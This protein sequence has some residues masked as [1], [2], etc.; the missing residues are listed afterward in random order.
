MKIT[1]T[2]NNNYNNNKNICSESQDKIFIYDLLFS[3][4]LCNLVFF[5]VYTLMKY[6]Y[7]KLVHF[8]TILNLFIVNEC[9]RKIEPSQTV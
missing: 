6:E 5:K 1:T 7:M 2:I 8:C 9:S 3:F 4:G